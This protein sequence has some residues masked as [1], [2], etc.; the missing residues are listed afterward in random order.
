L[1]VRRIKKN[2]FLS[3]ISGEEKRV[4]AS[5]VAL[6]PLSRNAQLALDGWVMD[7]HLPRFAFLL[8]YFSSCFSSV[9]SWYI[10][11]SFLVLQA[12]VYYWSLFTNMGR[13]KRTKVSAGNNTS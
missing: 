4:P 1:V 7:S 3:L 12:A 11:A 6:Q 5:S 2:F 8:A 10:F 13:L 9:S